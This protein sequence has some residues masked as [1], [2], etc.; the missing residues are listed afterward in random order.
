M[1][2][3]RAHP[4]WADV[5]QIGLDKWAT[6]APQQRERTVAL[7]QIRMGWHAVVRCT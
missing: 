7:W 6:L 1:L 5:A 2:L 3:H 4:Q